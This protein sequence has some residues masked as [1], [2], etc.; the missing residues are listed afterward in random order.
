MQ[1]LGLTTAEGYGINEGNRVE[2]KKGISAPSL[3]H[4]ISKN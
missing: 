2:G 4:V 1:S 3:V